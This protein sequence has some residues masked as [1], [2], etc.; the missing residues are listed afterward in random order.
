MQYETGH[1]PNRKLLDTFGDSLRHVNKIYNREF[2]YT[3]RKVPA[4]MAHMIDRHVMNE[5]QERW[6]IVSGTVHF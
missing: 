6:V 2:G 5:L 1:Q 4:H 3:A